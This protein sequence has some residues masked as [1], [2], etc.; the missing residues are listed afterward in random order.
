MPIAI[1]ARNATPMR[2]SPGRTPTTSSA[3]TQ[4]SPT[5][6]SMGTPPSEN[7]AGARAAA[8]H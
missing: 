5:S 1:H 8:Q 3:L 4:P 6:A 7:L 2:C